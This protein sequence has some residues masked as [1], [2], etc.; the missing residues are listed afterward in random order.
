VCSDLCHALY[1][2]HRKEHILLGVFV[3]T[4]QIIFVVRFIFWCTTKSVCRAF[5]F[6][7]AWQTIFFF[8][9]RG[10]KRPL[11]FAMRHVKAHD[12]DIIIF[13][14]RFP[15]SHGKHIPLSCI[16]LKRTTKYFLKILI[17]VLLF[18]SPLQKYYFV[19]YMSILYM[20]R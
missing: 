5:L 18:I 7:G 3:G 8:L 14:V 12:K 10:G 6:L 13:V 2:A 9:H 1:I 4:R 20:H 16:F 15:P 19:L 17:F 11:A